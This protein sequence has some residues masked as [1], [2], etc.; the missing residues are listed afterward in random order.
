MS[1]LDNL[2]VASCSY[3]CLGWSYLGVMFIL[4]LLGWSFQ[5]LLGVTGTE[6]AVAW[7]F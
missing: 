4:F 2:P 1:N 5:S 6:A 3:L 7:L